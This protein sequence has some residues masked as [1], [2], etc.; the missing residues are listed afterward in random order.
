MTTANPI[1]ASRLASRTES[2]CTVL[3]FDEIDAIGQLRGGGDENGGLASSGGSDGSS[4]RILAELLIQMTNIIKSDRC[5]DY[6][7]AEDNDRNSFKQGG[8]DSC[9]D[10]DEMMDSRSTLCPVKVIIVAA[11]NRIEDCDPALL[12]RFS[13]RLHVSL[14]T[15]RDRMK[16]INK[17]LSDIDNSLSKI[18]LEEIGHA[19][20]GWSGSDLESLTRE[21]AMAPIRECLRFAARAKRQTKKQEQRGG[22][23]SSQENIAKTKDAD[24]VA[25]CLLLKGFQNI[26]DVCFQDFE[27]AVSFLLGTNEHPRVATQSVIQQLQHR[28]QMYDSSSDSGSDLD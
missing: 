14:P 28:R 27:D 2:R 22:D 15:K 7:S 3:F 23:E 10:E 21:A 1:K 11:T 24:E 5:N 18:Q 25:R 4:R 17:H 19:T 12:R 8:Y 16:I 20:E 6:L 9:G 13:I 26:R